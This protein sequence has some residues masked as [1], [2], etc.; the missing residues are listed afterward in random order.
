MISINCRKFVLLVLLSPVFNCFSQIDKT[1]PK[2]REPDFMNDKFRERTSMFYISGNTTLE[3][4]NYYFGATNGIYSAYEHKLHK[5][6]VIG[7]GMGY[8]FHYRNAEYFSYNSRY[9]KL[10]R[11]DLSYKYYHNLKL[12]M[13]KGLTG[14]N[15]SANYLY[16]SPNFSFMRST[17]ELSGYSW[18]FTH[19]YWVITSKRE[20]IWEPRLKIGYGFQRVIRN[21]LNIDINAGIQISNNSDQWHPEQ[22]LFGQIT[23]GFIIK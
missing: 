21:K 4:I 23:I 17:S 22:L 7:V 3:S 9:D 12:R 16:V 8:F 6:H 14:N 15:F 1:L 20:I 19:G 18:D 11:L 10:L 13:S 2:E 5:Y